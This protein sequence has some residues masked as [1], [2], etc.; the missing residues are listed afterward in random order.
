MDTT[1]AGLVHGVAAGSS[2]ITATENGVS[3]S[4]LLTV[5]TAATNAASFVYATSFN[6]DSS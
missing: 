6:P 4:S 2:T 1:T 5:A 3:G